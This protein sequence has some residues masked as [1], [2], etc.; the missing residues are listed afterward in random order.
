MP[1]ILENAFDGY[2]TALFAYGQTSSGKSYTV[3]GYGKN[4]GIVPRMCEDL[5]NKI[6]TKKENGDKAQ[7]EIRFSMME[8][9]NEIVRDLCNNELKNKKGLKVREHPT[10]GF[11]GN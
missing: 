7:F 11:Y 4:K 10:K 3:V 8:I 2:N 6:K 5:F 1:S 9:Y